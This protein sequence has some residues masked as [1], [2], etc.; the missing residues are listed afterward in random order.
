MS[1]P[2]HYE[3]P[4]EHPRGRRDGEGTRERLLE[5]A[6]AHI[7]AAGFHKMSI[8][9]VAKDAGVSQS[10]LLHHFRSKAALLSAV[11]EQRESED[12][13]FLFGDGEV[14]LGWDA[15][16]AL[17]SLSARNSTRPEMVQLLVRIAAEA[18]DPAHPAHDWL[19][20]HYSGLRAWLSDAID[21]GIAEGT[22][23]EELPK[24]ATIST[25]I[26]VLDGLQQQWVLDSEAVAMTGGV[27]AYVRGLKMLWGIGPESS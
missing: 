21:R 12:N 20:R 8:A 13:L 2:A 16:D 7:S 5:V 23:K 14:P 26:A 24:A 1:F 15:F 11:L 6:A 22:M 4:P 10:G 3:R 27:R 9:S 18:T 17:V 25:A 19:A